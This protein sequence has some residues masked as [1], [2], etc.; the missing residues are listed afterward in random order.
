MVEK[1]SNKRDERTRN[2]VFVLYPDSAPS[3]WQEVLSELQIPLA[4][5]PLHDRCVNADGT[6][7]KQH[8]HVVL[9]FAGKKSFEQIKEITDSLN[10]PQPQKVANMVGMI[11]YLAHLDNPDKAQYAS[12]DIKTFGGMDIGKLLSPTVTERYACIREMCDYVK[13]TGI[14]DFCDLMDYAAVHRYEDWFKLLC[15]NAAFIVNNY[16]KSVRH[17]NI[18]Q[19]Y[20]A[21][22]HPLHDELTITDDGEILE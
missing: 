21:T 17:K 22:S 19:T 2:W 4:I 13:D 9:Q 1:K 3:N 20:T 14:T 16:I 10:A 6:P 18:N 15:D 11:R 12:S 5:S 7:K 8:W